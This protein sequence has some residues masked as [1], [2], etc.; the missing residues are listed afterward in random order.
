MLPYVS[1]CLFYGSIGHS[2]A[3]VQQSDSVIYA[4]FLF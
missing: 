4:S 2:V 3:G 1:I